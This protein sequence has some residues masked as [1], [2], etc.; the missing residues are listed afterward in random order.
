MAVNLAEQGLKSVSEG[1]NGI[2]QYAMPVAKIYEGIGLTATSATLLLD[3]P[4]T[5]SE[6]N[7]YVNVKG[8]IEIGEAIALSH[9]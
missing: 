2:V 8:T 6:S 4:A 9:R 7:R 3:V 1:R 5:R